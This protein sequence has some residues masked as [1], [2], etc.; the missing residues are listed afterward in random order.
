MRLLL[1]LRWRL[2]QQLLRLLRQPYVKDLLLLALLRPLAANEPTPRA[3]GRRASSSSGALRQ[4]PP[5]PRV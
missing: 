3:E 2:L 4:L 5:R 1:P